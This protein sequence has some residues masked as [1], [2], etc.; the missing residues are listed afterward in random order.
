MTLYIQPPP[1]DSPRLRPLVR[2]MIN[3]TCR[4]LM[5]F[6]DRDSSGRPKNHRLLLV[7]G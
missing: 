4:A 5:E 1:S 3:Q 7:T 6:L 2:L